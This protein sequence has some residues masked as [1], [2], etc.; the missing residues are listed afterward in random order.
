MNFFLCLQ[1]IQLAEGTNNGINSR[2]SSQAA[3]AAAIKNNKKISNGDI[4]ADVIGPDDGDSEWQVMNRDGDELVTR[5]RM[6]L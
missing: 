5:W 6:N 2:K 1:L 4:S 3:K